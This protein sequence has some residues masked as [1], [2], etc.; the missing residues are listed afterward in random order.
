MGRR[1]VRGWSLKAGIASAVLL[2]A[3]AIAV[4]A[5]VLDSTGGQIAS[6]ARVTFGTTGMQVADIV[7]PSAPGGVVARVDTRANV[8]L[9]WN[10]SVDDVGVTSYDVYRSISPTQMTNYSVDGSRVATVITTSA[11]V[12]VKSDEAS[13]SYTYNYVVVAK[14]ASSNPSPSLNVVPDPHG[15]S[16]GNVDTCTQCH[17]IHGGTGGAALGAASA[18]ACY[19]CHGTTVATAAYGAVRPSTSRRGSRTT[20]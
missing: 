15:Q 16:G 3:V 10:P 14:D 17:S 12:P 20:A 19:T 4:A 2:G 6:P 9:T 1:E 5:N 18:A 8:K 13:K 11:T 7:P